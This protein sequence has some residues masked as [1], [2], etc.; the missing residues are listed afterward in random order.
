MYGT[1]ILTVSIDE[2]RNESTFCG[3][4][5]YRINCKLTFRSFLTIHTQ[6]IIYSNIMYQNILIL[7][8]VC[9]GRIHTSV[10]QTLKVK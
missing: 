8:L 6:Q 3:S 10:V 2:K 7:N 1:G 9:F 5:Y 4:F